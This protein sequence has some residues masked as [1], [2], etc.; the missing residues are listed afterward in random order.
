MP[1]Y[2]LS[3]QIADSPGYRERAVAVLANLT[4]IR[5]RDSVLGRK[6][7]SQDVHTGCQSERYQL[8]NLPM[9]WNNYA[10][11]E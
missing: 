11:Y 3:L 8:P 5:R 2:H 9:E 6:A 4:R 7:V 1:R 10:E